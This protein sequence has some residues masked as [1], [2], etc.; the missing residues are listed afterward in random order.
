MNPF[1]LLI[2][3]GALFLMELESI[4]CQ[5]VMPERTVTV[6]I[7]E[8][9]PFEAATDRKLWYTLSYTSVS[10]K[11]RSLYVPGHI[12]QVSVA[13]D[14][15]AFVYFLATPI[16]EFNPLGGVLFPDGTE[17]I[18]LHYE[19]GNLVSFFV[20]LD[21]NYTAV[22]NMVNYGKVRQKLEN[23]NALDAF[24]RRKLASDLLNGKLCDSSFSVQDC[25]TVTTGQ[26][27]KGHWIS[28]D[29]REEGFWIDGT[30]DKIVTLFLCE[31]T[32]RYLETESGRMLTVVVDASDRKAY[33]TLSKAPPC[34]L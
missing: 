23:M 30:S 34:L 13:V 9:H 28:E 31:G 12:D 6:H 3:T 10:G 17:D 22:V 20:S 16:G 8:V 32:H 29:L 5:L 2:L 33:L 7:D 15:N 14:R 19:D 24:D 26:V 27:P 25:L 21:Q 4:S 1:R 11:L 18:Y